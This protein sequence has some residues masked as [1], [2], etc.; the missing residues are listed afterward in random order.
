VKS[1]THR[2][3][4]NSSRTG[5]RGALGELLD[6]GGVTGNDNLA[7]GIEIRRNHNVVARRHIGIA[8]YLCAQLYDGFVLESDNGSH[9]AGILLSGDLH[10][11]AALGDELEPFAE[12][13]HTD[14]MERRVLPETVSGDDLC[15]HIPGA[16]Q[17]MNCSAVHVHGWLSDLRL[18]E[19]LDRPFKADVAERVLEYFV[20]F[21]KK[22][23]R[24]GMLLVEITP[25]TDRL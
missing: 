8:A 21:V 7:G 19:P 24:L 25:H 23:A 10:E 1:A 11:P 16:E 6:G 15:A 14:R 5:R 20:R 12:T 4:Q 3:F 2:Q 18:T 17:G 9:L 22:L 13:E